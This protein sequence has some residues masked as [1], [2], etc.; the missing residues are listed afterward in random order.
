MMPMVCLSSILFRSSLK[1]CGKR[2]RLAILK[3]AGGFCKADAR[4]RENCFQ[5]LLSDSE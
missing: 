1:G 5:S 2:L 4:G 3:G